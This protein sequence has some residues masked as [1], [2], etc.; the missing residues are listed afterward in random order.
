MTYYGHEITRS[1]NCAN[2]NAGKKWQI[3]SIHAGTGLKYSEQ[4]GDG[5]YTLAQ[6]K[7]AI[8]IQRSYEI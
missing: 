7:E 8:R 1:T 3:T 2:V 4:D 6:A 5:Y